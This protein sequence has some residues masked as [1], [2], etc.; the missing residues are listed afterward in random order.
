MSQA[1]SGVTYQT[2]G[3]FLYKRLH[4]QKIVAPEHLKRVT[5]RIFTVRDFTK[6]SRKFLKDLLY[7]KTPKIV[8][9]I[10]Y[11]SKSTDFWD[12]TKIFISC[13]NYPFKNAC[14]I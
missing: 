8:K 14:R 13:C 4:G 2:T 1:A 11:H 7:K 10:S 3:G 5:G 12:L 9:A 6:A